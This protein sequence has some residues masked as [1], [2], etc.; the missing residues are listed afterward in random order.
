MPC[1]V[2]TWKPSHDM[3]KDKNTG[4][5]FLMISNSDVVERKFLLE[6]DP[7]NFKCVFVNLMIR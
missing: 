1:S 4:T 3:Q 2:R 5:R 6:S 7:S